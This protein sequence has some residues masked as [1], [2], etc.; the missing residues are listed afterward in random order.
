MNTFPQKFSATE[1]LERAF[2]LPSK[3]YSDE[4]IYKEELAQVFGKAWQWVG[5]SS[6]IAEVGAFL[7]AKLGVDP[8]V[9]V[10]TKDGFNGFY[11]VCKHRGGPLVKDQQKSGKLSYNAF[12]CQYHGWTYRLNGELRGVPSFDKAELFDKSDFA[13]EPIA[14]EEW[15]GGI[16]ACKSSKEKLANLSEV[17]EGVSERMDGIKVEDYRFHQR[18]SYPLNCNW[19]VY[20][21]NFLEGYHIPV[22]HPE[23]ARLIDYKRYVTEMHGWHSLQHAPFRSGKNV[24][25]A[26]DGQAWYWFVF[27]NIMLNILPGRMQVNVIEPMGP[28]QCQVHFDYYYTDIVKAIESG[29]VKGDLAY[30]ESIQQ[31]DIEICEAVQKG[32]ASPAYEKGRFSPDREAGVWHFQQLYQA[33]MMTKD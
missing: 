29:L 8:I 30:S 28:T 26:E 27:P 23:L 3:A 31:E 13:L 4:T 14:I 18:L 12:I 2:T 19:K 15:N 17:L 25:Q 9:V 5:H 32:L 6:E 24:Y 11:N 10:R 7:T 21:D 33:V 20:V 1:S 16:F 22:V